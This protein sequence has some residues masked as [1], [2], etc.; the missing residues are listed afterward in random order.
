M[1]SLIRWLYLNY[2]YRIFPLPNDPF[3]LQKPAADLNISLAYTYKR[4]GMDVPL[5]QQRITQ[6]LNFLAW[7]APLS[8][9]MLCLALMVGAVFSCSLIGEDFQSHF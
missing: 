8:I 6:R 3:R 7:S 4:Y 9:V 2:K 1:I 5:V